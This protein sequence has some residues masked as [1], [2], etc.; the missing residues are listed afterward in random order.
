MFTKN[1]LLQIATFI[2][3]TTTCLFSCQKAPIEI[4]YSGQDLSTKA[5][6]IRNKDTKGASLSITDQKEWKLYAGKS[7]AE[8][9]L[10]KPV[11]EGE[12][13]GIFPINL[14]DNNHTY[15][16][17][18]T[19][20]G[21]AIL[22]ERHLPMAGGY[23]F[24]D[25]GGF[26]TQDGRYTKWG[27]VFRS[28]D[29]HNLTEEDLNYLSSIPMTNIV[30]F[31]SEEEISKAADK[32]P[33]S[34]KKNYQLSID[35][36]NVLDFARV[37]EKTE[38]EMEQMMMQLNEVLVSDST[39]I[40]RYKVFF[41]QLQDEQEVP[42]MFHCSAGKDR[43]GMAAA[44]ILHALGVDEDTIIQDYLSSNDYL[45][46]K[47][48]ALKKEHPSFSA[49]FEVRQQYLQA[50]LNKIKE[51]YG[52]VDAFLTDVLEVDIELMKEKYLY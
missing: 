23:N 33:A 32:N 31:R 4:G 39:C 29:L 52:S 37:A 25:L 16:Q 35:P 11:L 46:D 26:K 43:T 12:G 48:A 13:D 3:F 47:Y 10:S 19:E 27:K 9:D 6:I 18:V 49:L 28:D 50:G 5:T 1:K 24:R 44:L 14:P 40:D 2:M 8:I 34:L 38:A 36:G 20:Q 30:D 41:K 45:G 22:A 42:L 7:V 15:F 17:L 21:S 51:K